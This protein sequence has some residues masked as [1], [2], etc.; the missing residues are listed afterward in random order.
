MDASERDI[1]QFLKSW[2]EEF[3][4]VKEIA[5]RAGGKRKYHEDPEWAKPV[6]IRMAERGIL[7]SNITGHYRLKPL[8]KNKKHAK[9]VSPAI[10]KILNDGGVKVQEIDDT[11]SEVGSDEHYEQL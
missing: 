5:R 11:Q 9:W 3:V 7:E 1:F 4:N 8:A 10:A 2:G 6:V